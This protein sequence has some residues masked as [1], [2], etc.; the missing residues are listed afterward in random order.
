MGPQ[1]M[2][3]SLGVSQA[4]G[5]GRENAVQ[6]LSGKDEGGLHGLGELVY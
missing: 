2:G 3:D 5:D 4:L 1:S 6:V